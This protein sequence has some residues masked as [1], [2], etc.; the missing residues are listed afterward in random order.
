M[1]DNLTPA[2]RTEKLLNNPGSLTPVTRLEKFIQRSGGGGSGGMSNAVKQA[3]LDCFD[4]VAWEIPKNAQDPTGQDY[5]YALED[6]L[7]PVTPPAEVVS[8]TAVYTQSGT[9]YDTDSLNS[10]KD[11][12]VVTAYYDDETSEVV[13]NYTL[14]GTLAEGTSTITVGYGGKT[15]TFN[16]VVTA[17]WDYEWEFTDGLPETVGFVKGVGG[18]PT[19]SMLS[20]GLNITCDASGEYVR[21]SPNNTDTFLLAKGVLEVEFMLKVSGPDANGVRLIMSNGTDGITI[22]NNSSY[23][24]YIEGST[25]KQIATLGNNVVYK[26]RLEYTEGGTQNVYL[27]D[28]LIYTT[29]N[30]CNLYATKSF[31]YVQDNGTTGVLKSMRWHVDS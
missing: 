12:L 7:Y 4:H 30:V 18:T 14:S 15:A 20:D 31:V 21:Y 13:T 25:P 17:Y 8:I 9:V 27:N 1:A 11:D 29:Q 5:I 6:A 23:C 24:L 10:L 2:T 28:N 3:L 26:E 19:I 22:R 16:V